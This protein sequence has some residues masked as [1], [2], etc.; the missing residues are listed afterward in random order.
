MFCLYLNRNC[1]Q[2]S[3][4]I[5]NLSSML[6]VCCA[7]KKFHHRC[8]RNTCIIVH[9][10]E[11]KSIYETCSL[12]IC[13]HCCGYINQHFLPFCHIL[14]S[15]Q[16]KLVRDSDTTWKYLLNNIIRTYHVN[17]SVTFTF[18]CSCRCFPF[19]S[20]LLLYNLLLEVALNL[21]PPSCF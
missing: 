19:L 8:V 20:H 7:G 9:V 15:K 10:F 14:S 13:L 6:L 2:D 3:W 18:Y 17:T 16:Q 11:I 4:F 5:I 12:N 21:R 1:C